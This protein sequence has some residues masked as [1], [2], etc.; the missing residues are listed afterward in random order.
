[1]GSKLSSIIDDY[2]R[3]LKSSPLLAGQV[4]YH[5]V[6]P[7]VAPAWYRSR[8]PWP[9]PV[10][11]AL[12]EIGI[13]RL[14]AHQARAM[15]ALRANRSV[16]VATPT[17]SGKT[18]IY[19]L[20]VLEKFFHNTDIRA[21]YLFPLKALAQDQLRVFQEI[22][23]AMEGILPAAAIYD[24]DTTAWRRKKIR[25]HPP[26][27]LLTNP[28][29]LHLSLLPHHTKWAGFLKRLQMVVVDEVHTYRGIMG[30]HMAQVFRR[31]NRV[32][33]RYGAHP[34]YLF[35]S[36][37]ISNPSQLSEQ[38]TGI[39]ADPV[40]ESGAGRGK[41]HLLFI[42]PTESA[43]RM[44]IVLLKAALARNLRTIVYTQSRK[45]TELIA[46]WAATQ[47]GPYSEKISA[48]RA[49][50]LPEER[51][52]VEHRLSTG[53]LL[54]VISTS[55]LELGIDIG[56]LD[57]CILVGYPGSIIA[58][59]QRGGR[60]G[61]SGQD[62]AMILIAGEDALDQY[63]MR[64]PE[65]FVNRKPEAAVINPHNPTILS[66]HLVCAA[67]EMPLTM[68]EPFLSE[69]PV[70]DAVSRLEASGELL[71]S[72]D[73]NVLYS[74]RRSP[75]RDVDLRGAGDRFIISGE[76]GTV[77]GE[78]DGFRAF[79]ET[80]PGAVYLHRGKPFL[81]RRL[82][83]ST[84]TVHAVS[85]KV[86]YYTR[87]RGHKDTEILE[88]HEEKPAWQTR[89]Y[90]GRL[91]V[92]DQVT[93]YEKRRITGGKRLGIVPLDL[94]PLVF[95]T[96][97]LW[98]RIP[99]EVQAK[100]EQAFL[101]FMG[102][103]HA[104]EHAGIGIFP[105][106]VMTDRNDLGGIA[107]PYQ[108]Q[109]KGPAIF[110]YDGIPGGAGLTRQAFQQAEELLA[111]TQRAVA[112]CPCETGCPSCVHSPKCGSGNRPIDKASAL[113]ILQALRSRDVAVLER[114]KTARIPR[115][116]HH[117]RDLLP[118][119][120][121][122]VHYGILDLETQRSAEE[123]GGWHR[124]DLMRISC[125]VLYD[126]K[127]DDYVEYLEKDIPALIERLKCLDLVVGFNIK[128]F[129]YGVLR[130]Y[131]DFAFETLP[132]LDILEEIHHRLG[133]RLSLNHLAGVTLGKEKSG[134]GL[135]ALAWWR[136][137]RIQEILDY[138][139]RDVEIT[140]DLLHFGIKNGF[141]LFK[142]KQGQRVRIPVGWAFLGRPHR[143]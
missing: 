87:V 119:Q 89:V 54:A 117:R 138:C 83:L 115:E 63:F 97:G 29:M 91:K 109:V 18:L 23:G 132:T 125:A 53:D 56:D 9:E 142:N 37:T 105:L 22:T 5:R 2:V 103:I 118:P 8:K 81:V 136:D 82:D 4:L 32:C 15:D 134:D 20:P 49:G 36:A 69:K 121:S 93:G 52:E 101:H 7:P 128:R 44:A 84:R 3:A 96:E 10:Q 46:L 120:D 108:F 130:G 14:Y 74:K 131:S 78:V 129:D 30:S 139:R 62:S 112:T 127:A 19:T 64:N 102:G 47:A 38:L 99:P 135:Q 27:I 21:L 107:M 33:A 26:N 50:F 79:K 106:L 12:N 35:S 90:R 140:R 31:F 51:R 133:Y 1:M 116:R 61:R 55:A 42:N 28:E 72:A 68:E 143:G 73:G 114:K 24:G 123:V 88:I 41:R 11:K 98:Y 34:A 110:I 17:A 113:F 6:F 39:Q 85:A 141:L 70:Y 67:A 16:V 65:D 45:L 104:M 124:S 77:I 76:N 100:T 59:W 25:E 60:V 66:K 92:T 111:L 71:R 80:H 43:A 126:S 57:L 40:T 94:P 95:E 86:D 13:H 75:H 58:T 122:V 48:Y 137:G